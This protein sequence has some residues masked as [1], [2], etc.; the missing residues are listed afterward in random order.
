VEPATRAPRG[1]QLIAN[2]TNARRIVA[3]MKS[4]ELEHFAQSVVILRHVA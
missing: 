4:N 2:A 3:V 1:E